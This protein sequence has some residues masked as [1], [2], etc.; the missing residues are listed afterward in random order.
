MLQA[1]PLRRLGLACLAIVGLSIANSA[2]GETPCTEPL[3]EGNPEVFQWKSSISQG[4]SGNAIEYWLLNKSGTPNLYVVWH[5]D[6]Y[7]GYVRASPDF[8]KVGRVQPLIGDCKVQDGSIEYSGQTQQH[9]HSYVLP[10]PTPSAR[11]ISSS[12]SLT[13]KRKG[14][15]SDLKLETSSEAS[16][17]TIVYSVNLEPR[18]FSPLLQ[19][20]WPAAASKDFDTVQRH[21]RCSGTG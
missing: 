6:I 18:E 17:K 20:D 13:I 15:F 19:F 8:K 11:K 9:A 14:D 2:K 16:E 12:F 3:I 21:R 10:T 4:Q 5:P 1:R 7:D